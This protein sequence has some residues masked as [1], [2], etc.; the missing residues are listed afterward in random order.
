[1]AP[2]ATSRDEIQSFQ[3]YIFGT[4][5]SIVGALEGLS[6][7][8]MAPSLA[9]LTPADLD[10]FRR[11]PRRGDITGREVLIVVARHAAEHWGE[12]QLT[13]SLMRA[14]GAAT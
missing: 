12:V 1:M 13:R 9:T 11:H 14:R 7:E 2:D 5:D 6:A 10:G 8:R 4:I 3:R